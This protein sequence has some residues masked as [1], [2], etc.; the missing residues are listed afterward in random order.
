MK[1]G[2]VYMLILI[3]VI[4]MG[5]T[6]RS[7]QGMVDEEIYEDN[8]LPIPVKIHLG[9]SESIL[10]GAEDEKV[11]DWK[12]KEF[13]VYAFNN[14]LFTTLQT[15][16]AE[17]KTRCL[18][19]GSIDE[20]GSLWGKKAMLDET[21]NIVEWQGSEKDVYYPVASQ[22]GVIY[23]FYAYYVGD[24]KVHDIYRGEETIDLRME[25][26]GTQDIMSSVAKVKEEQLAAFPDEKD[27]IYMEHYCY[28]YYTAQH[29]IDPVFTFKH[30]LAKLEFTV[31]PA[32]NA[33]GRR[34]VTILAI[35]VNSLYL[36][37][38]TVV[39]NTNKESLGMLFDDDGEG[40]GGYKRLPLREE[41]KST[42]SDS[43]YKV[44]TLKNSSSKVNSLKVGGEI[45][46]APDK[47]Y[48]VYVRLQ[49]TEFGGSDVLKSG[50]EVLKVSTPGGFQAG[51]SYNVD[52]KVYGELRL[53]VSVSLTEWKDG[54]DVMVDD[55]DQFNT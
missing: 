53:D 10:K 45:L 22:S 38:F 33:T 21:S 1:R 5:C 11:F 4:L 39:N 51:N 31:T 16:S 29:G 47:T 17:D 44:T 43:T 23:D 26:D 34:D 7:Y 40:G 13:F 18:V 14:D 27:R 41:D 48:D 25:I 19:D 28:S 3:A 20:P 55:E 54:E 15:T 30:H 50:T 35:D 6:D 52:I 49:E 24:A 36:A 12:G 42:L 37:M 8:S 32:Y 9:T 2:M 46:L